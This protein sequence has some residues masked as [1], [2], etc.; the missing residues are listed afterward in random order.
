MGAAGPAG[1]QGAKGDIGAVGPAGAGGAP[2][3][4]GDTGAT[5]PQGPKGETGATGQA[6]PAG[7]QGPPG[8]GLA[9][10]DGLAGTVCNTGTPE[11]GTLSLSY[12]SVS[13][14]LTLTCVPS[15]LYSLSVTTT[16]GGSG[17]VTSS[18]AGIECGATCSASFAIHRVVTLTAT[19]EAG[20]AGLAGSAFVGWSGDCTGS[21]ATCTVTMDS[22]KNVTAT[23]S[24]TLKLLVAATSPGV[25]GIVSGLAAP[26]ASIHSPSTC[27]VTYPSGT[28]VQ[29]VAIPDPG[30]AFGG[31]Q[32]D[33]TGLGTCTLTM[34]GPK[35]VAALFNP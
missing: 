10:V 7:P 16:G 9:G 27:S 6:G 13:G 25:G 26:C 17:T 12:E 1:P 29:L 18:P 8:A 11:V 14:N 34:D 30:F 2:G 15:T 19:A 3:P 5:G 32:G 21:T 22:A 31:W 24:P 33:C 35:T 28:V 23:F 4:K 20:S